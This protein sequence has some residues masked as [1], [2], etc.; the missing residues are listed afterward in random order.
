MAKAALFAGLSMLAE[1]VCVLVM[2]MHLSQ[3]VN[4]HPSK[5]SPPIQS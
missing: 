5:V 1:K 3:T 2:R 4:D